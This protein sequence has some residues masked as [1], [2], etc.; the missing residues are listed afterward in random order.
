[1]VTLMSFA[2][3]Q[4]S[5]NEHADAS[6]PSPGFWWRLVRPTVGVGMSVWGILAFVSF[7][8]PQILLCIIR[9]YHHKSPE[10][11]KP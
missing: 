2:E 8:K 5:P 9:N 11:P 10:N 3:I 1:M 7:D 6:F 4:G